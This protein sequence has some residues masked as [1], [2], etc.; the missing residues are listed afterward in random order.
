MNLA[1]IT[2]Q[3]LATHIFFV[4]THDVFAAE[5]FWWLL[6]T[7]ERLL[8]F[9]YSLFSCFVFFWVTHNFLAAHVFWVTHDF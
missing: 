8:F 1:V 3:Y 7:F 6:M 5:E 2:S 9:G 4:V